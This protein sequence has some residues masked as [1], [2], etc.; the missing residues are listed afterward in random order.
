[1]YISSLV[2]PETAIGVI[3]MYVT[4]NKILHSRM[5]RGAKRTSDEWQ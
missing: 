3:E 1:L 5:E 2:A 4:V